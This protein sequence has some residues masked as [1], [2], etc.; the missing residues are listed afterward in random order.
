MPQQVE[1]KQQSVGNPE[2][3]K[4]L[5]DA[6]EYNQMQIVRL[7]EAVKN[8]LDKTQGV[9]ALRDEVMARTEM[10]LPDNTS[11]AERAVYIAANDIDEIRYLVEDAI[12]E[13]R[14]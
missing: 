12:H 6:L 2:E 8:Y 5:W 10:Q 3:N 9:R 14:L 1:L 7:K 11:E 13:L 4:S